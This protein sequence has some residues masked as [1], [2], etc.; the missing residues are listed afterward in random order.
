[1][2]M[3]WHA[4]MRVQPCPAGLPRKASRVLVPSTYKKAFLCVCVLGV[5][6]GFGRKGVSF[7]PP[8]FAG[9]LTIVHHQMLKAWPGYQQ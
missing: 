5:R 8:L 2:S 4:A 6:L 7:Q 9:C 3:T 1:M